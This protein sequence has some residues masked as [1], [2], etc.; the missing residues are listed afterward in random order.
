MNSIGVF[1]AVSDGYQAAEEFPKRIEFLPIDQAD[2]ADVILID[3][4]GHEIPAI[5]SVG[6]PK[7]Q[8]AVFTDEVPQ[9]GIRDNTVAEYVKVIDVSHIGDTSRENQAIVEKAYRCA[10]VVQ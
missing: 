7:H 6:S 8:P 3:G 1:C 5:Q 2:G 4:E 9:L 10:G